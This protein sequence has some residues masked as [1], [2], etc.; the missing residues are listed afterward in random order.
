S[1]AFEDLT[2]KLR[3]AEDA[4]NKAMEGSASGAAKSKLKDRVDELRELSKETEK[5]Q[6]RLQ[7]LED[8]TVGAGDG[9]NEM[10]DA[11]KRRNFYQSAAPIPDELGYKIEDVLKAGPDSDLWA[12]AT[13]AYKDY[14]NATETVS[15]RTEAVADAFTALGDKATSTSDS[16]KAL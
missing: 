11:K 4:L 3:A 5:Y 9:V 2:G 14:L 7:A 12:E 15:G 1:Q 13:A 8:Q 6:F 16:A 10:F